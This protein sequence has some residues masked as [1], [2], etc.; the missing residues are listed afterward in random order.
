MTRLQR[1]QTIFLMAALILANASFGNPGIEYPRGMSR[2]LFQANSLDLPMKAVADRAVI[3][4]RIGDAGPYNFLI[5]TGASLS[6]VDTK[7]ALELG[8]DVVGSM[9][10]GAPGGAQVESD[11]VSI[12]TMTAAGLTIENL[13]PVAVAIDEMS[14][15]LMQGVL[16]MDLFEEVLLTVDPVRGITTLSHDRLQAGAPGVIGFD[17]SMGRIVFDIEVAGMT[18]PMQIDTGA[19]GSFT[20]PADLQDQL[21]TEAGSERKRTAKLVGGEREVTILRLAGK[22]A[23]AGLHFDKPD[24]AFMRPS[25]TIGN[26][27][28]QILSDLVVSVDQRNGLVSFLPAT[29]TRSTAVQRTNSGEGPRRLGVRFGGPGG[30]LADVGAVDSNSLGERAG[31]KAGDTILTLNGKPMAEI[32]MAELGS[33]IRGNGLLSFVVERQGEQLVIEID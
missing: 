21:P 32:G 15:G 9:A 8:L 22:V 31:F 7:I 19:P 24:V 6:V 11:R 4:V 12:P 29:K 26:I 2:L 1:A 33:T 5:D 17:G 23:F 25:P 16:G 13:T 3:E 14:A 30:T 10:V 28:Q 18:V 20:L 27:G